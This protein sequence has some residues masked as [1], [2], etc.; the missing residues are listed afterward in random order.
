MLQLPLGV[1]LRDASRFENFLIGPNAAAVHAVQAVATAAAASVTWLWGARGTGRSHLLQAVCALAGAQ[2]KVSAHLP[3][4]ELAGVGPGLLAGLES[5]SVVAIDDVDHVAGVTEWERALF[6][7]YNAATE[8]ST[9]LILAASS[10]P[11]GI[12]WRL[13]DLASRFSAATVFHLRALDDADLPIALKHRAR[14]RGLELPADSAEFLLKRYPRDMHT[15]CALLDTL[16]EASLVAQRRLTV[17]FLKEVLE[18]RRWGAG[19]APR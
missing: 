18:H 17:P 7:L 14:L 9:S 4:A 15:L 1:R 8:A 16:D 2:G 6:N 11:A 13:G 3:L 19:D 12:A 5:L 10:P